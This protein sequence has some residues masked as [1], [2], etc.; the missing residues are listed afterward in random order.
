MDYLITSDKLG[1]V[2]VFKINSGIPQEVAFTKVSGTGILNLD[3]LMITPHLL[4]I[5]VFSNDRN[6]T[7]LSLC[8]HSVSKKLRSDYL[9]NLSRQFE[10]T[11][12]EGKS[13]TI[14]LPLSKTLLVGNFTR[15]SCFK[16]I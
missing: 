8:S 3:C 12:I 13:S 2:T 9:I 15:S 5:Q 7:F 10:S 14:F 1:N 6:L 4:S 11:D 16:M